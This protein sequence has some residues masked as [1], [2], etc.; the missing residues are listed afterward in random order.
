MLG[1]RMTNSKKVSSTKVCHKPVKAIM[2]TKKGTK[3]VVKS[4]DSLRSAARW[5]YEKGLTCSVNAAETSICSAALGRE[6]RNGNDHARSTA[7]GF[8]WK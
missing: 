5:V 4:F 1:D 6:S 3:K 7:Y 8:E 2:T